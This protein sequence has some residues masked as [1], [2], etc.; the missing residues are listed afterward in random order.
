MVVI[1]G[2]SLWACQCGWMDLEGCFFVG[3]AVY[4]CQ[5]DCAGVSC[6]C[7]CMYVRS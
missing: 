1:V 2:V 5:N 6:M 3:L 7:L 4:V